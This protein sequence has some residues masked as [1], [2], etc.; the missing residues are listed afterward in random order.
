M[1]VEISI[2]VAWGDMDAY[3]HVNNT[4][5]LK[6]C[7]S[8]RIAFFQ[9]IG[10]ERCRE[11]TGIGAILASIQCRYKAPVTYPDTI[12]VNI[13]LL[14]LSPSDFELSY[15]ISSQ[16]LGRI[17]A[18]ASDRLVAYDYRRL[19]KAQW[20]PDILSQLESFQPSAP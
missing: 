8:A 12:T 3:S 15:I 18:E 11:A 4:V 6:W 16:Q 2:P 10:L 5:F 17:V 9:T 13:S 19:A 1:P 20:P 14:R 7:E